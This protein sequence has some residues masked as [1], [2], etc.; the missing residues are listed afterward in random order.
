[1][2]VAVQSGCAALSKLLHEPK[3]RDV[4]YTKA[5][6]HAAGALVALVPLL[7]RLGDALTLLLVVVGHLALSLSLLALI[8]WYPPD[9]T[10]ISRSGST[11]LL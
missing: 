9:A 8:A 5:M 4:H 11:P 2:G 7:L 3:R 10:S 6:L 1:M